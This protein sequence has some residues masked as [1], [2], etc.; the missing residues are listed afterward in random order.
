MI[1]HCCDLHRRALV[2]AHPSLNGIDFLEVLDLDAPPGSPRQRTLLVRLLKPVPAGLSPDNLHIDGGE[3]IRQIGVEWLGI[4]SAPPA[5][6]SAAEQALLLALTQPEHVLVVRTDSEGDHSTYRLQLHQAGTLATALPNFDPR[7][8]AVDFAFKV[9]CPSDFDCKPQHDCPQP[10]QTTPDINYLARDYASLRRLVMDRLARQMPGW[11]DRSPA[12]LATTL[13]ELIAY[14]GDLQHYQ[15]D[16]VSTEAYLHSARKRSSLRRHAL[17]VDYQ[18]H[19]GCNARAWL[20]LEVSGGPFALPAGL[21]FYTKV[22]GVPARILA[23]SPEERLALQ[24]RPLVFEPMHGV[25]LRAAHNRLFFHTWSDARCCLPVGA[26]AATLRGHLPDL[27]AGD[28]LLLQEVMGPLSGEPADADPARRHAVRLTQVRAFD[29]TDPLL[30]PLDDSEITEIAWHADDALPFALCISSEAD[31]AHGSAQLDDVSIALGNMLLVDHGRSIADET[32]ESVPAPAWQYPASGGACQRQAPEPLPPRY[33]PLLA[34]APVTHQG[35]VQ[36]RVL[37]G[38]LL[39]REWVLF[40]PAASASAALRWRSADAI[41]ALRLESGSSGSPQHWSGQ[42]NLLESK[43][44]DRHFVLETEHDGSAR[45]RFGDDH[46]GRRPDSGTAFRAFYRVGNGPA[47]NVGAGSIAHVVSAEARILALGNPLPARGGVAPENVAELR[48]A[49]PQ[50][51]RTQERAVTPDDYAQVTERLAGVQRA[52]AGLR[53]TGSWHTVFVTVDRDAGEPVDVPF[54]SQVVEHLDRYRMAGHDLRVNEPLYVSLELDLLV[55]VK[56]GYFRSDVRRGL[57][58][59][60]SNRRHAF[61]R[62]GLFHPDN[63]SFGQTFYLSPL[64][65][66]A[67]TVAGVAAVQVTRFQRQGQADP[68]PLADGFMHLGRLEIARLDNDPNFPEHGVLRL[69]LHGGK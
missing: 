35:R 36:R 12:D 4:A 13:G 53:W 61:G 25:V 52:A 45:L 21:R 65:A 57:L 41:A 11:R 44:E 2:D 15:L 27:A 23:D 42:C 37:E 54:A 28:V 9:E 49:A 55:C 8:S 51:F 10:A 19:E 6:A 14:V 18:L 7:L 17:L 39:R 16:A 62:L 56:A 67:R 20:H 38:G 64:Y 31:E 30:D 43:A 40:D 59:V 24:S 58:D 63:F 32:L 60:L 48:R 46:H 69:A 47:G 26:T 29:G 33:R 68:K 1:Y 66:A 3:R 34:E 22:P 50:A 5:Q